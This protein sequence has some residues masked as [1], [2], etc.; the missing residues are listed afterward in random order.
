M[1]YLSL[2][3]YPIIIIFSMFLKVFAKALLKKDEQK[4]DNQLIGLVNELEK[5]QS[6]SAKV[7]KKNAIFDGSFFSYF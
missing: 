3:C 7:Q 1:F 6:L 5:S 4:V 2:S